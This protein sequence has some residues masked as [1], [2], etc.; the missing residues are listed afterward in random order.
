MSIQ[1]IND[2][3][4][5]KSLLPDIESVFNHTSLILEGLSKIYFS[6]K[7]NYLTSEKLINKF[8]PI[9]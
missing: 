4:F 8:L 9:T 1:I 7:N 3:L 2:I 5:D 6:N